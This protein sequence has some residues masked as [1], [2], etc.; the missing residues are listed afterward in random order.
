MTP[1]ELTSSWGTSFSPTTLPP[2][3]AQ[4]PFMWAEQRGVAHQLVGQQHGEGLVTDCFRG[5]PTG[6]PEARGDVL[7]DDR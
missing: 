2:V 3:L 1:Y 4:I 6:V 5:A 7:V